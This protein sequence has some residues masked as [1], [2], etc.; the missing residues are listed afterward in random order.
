MQ[1][2]IGFE[3]TGL[4]FSGMIVLAVAVLIGILL[5][6][7]PKKTK[8]IAL[9]MTG[10][11]AIILVVGFI[12]QNFVLD[13]QHTSDIYF[14]PTQGQ[15]FAIQGEEA[16][17]QLICFGD[18]EN[19]FLAEGTNITPLQTD[20]KNINI[21]EST[22]EAGNT[23][24]GLTVFT[25]FLDAEAVQ[26]G[27][28]SFSRIILKDLNG[29]EKTFE[30]GKINIDGQEPKEG[31]AIDI[32][33]HLG[34]ASRGAQYSFSFKNGASKPCTIT[35]IDFGGLTPYV[36]S[37]KVTVNDKQIDIQKDMTIQPGDVAYVEAK[38]K[39]TSEVDIYLISA[40][41]L[42]QIQGDSKEYC[43]TLPY[44]TI[45]L[46]DSEESFQTLAE[47]YM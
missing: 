24:K 34:V 40:N 6:R 1:T 46:P 19:P 29:N 45:G 20:N 26:P 10:V 38:L 37:V 28:Q 16:S 14:L 11:L 43:Y 41:L 13:G 27:N 4:L 36:Q 33:E 32:R 31:S 3:P 42:Y 22:I 21:V 15:I 30:I 39:K 2:I 35:G 9:G 25:I 12:F 5:W 18:K 17:I 7:A 47:K 8:A 44:G 23:Y